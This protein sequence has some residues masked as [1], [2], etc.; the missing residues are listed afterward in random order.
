MVIMSVSRVGASVEESGLPFGKGGEGGE[1]DAGGSRDDVLDF[2]VGFCNE[3][4]DTI[5]YCGDGSQTFFPPASGM[6]VTGLLMLGRSF[7]FKVDLLSPVS[8][9]THAISVFTCF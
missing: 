8:Y 9:F 2:N 4:K 7:M 5:D 6:R 3:I 1:V